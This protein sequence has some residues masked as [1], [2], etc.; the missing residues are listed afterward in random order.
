MP[1]AL[2]ADSTGRVWQ[3]DVGVSQHCLLSG[4]WA[5]LGRGTSRWLRTRQLTGPGLCLIQEHPLVAAPEPVPGQ[6]RLAAA[7]GSD[8]TGFWRWEEAEFVGTRDQRCGLESWP[9][10][11]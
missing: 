1:E 9:I 4:S 2:A 5:G 11:G 10:G 6:V 8:P 7:P 3:A